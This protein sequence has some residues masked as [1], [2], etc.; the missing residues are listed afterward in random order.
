MTH[1]ILQLTGALL[2]IEAAI[3]VSIYYL[4]IRNVIFEK[5]HLHRIN[6]KVQHWV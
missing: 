3:A 6:K 5:N 4:V 1:N 2:E